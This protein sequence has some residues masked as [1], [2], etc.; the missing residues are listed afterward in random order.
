MV[1]ENLTRLDNLTSFLHKEEIPTYVY[2]Q[3]MSFLLELLIHESLSYV[4][5]EDP[6]LFA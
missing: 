5:I 2:F 4:V 6:D 1:H 3:R